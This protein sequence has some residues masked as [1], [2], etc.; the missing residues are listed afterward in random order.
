M[1]WINLNAFSAYVIPVAVIAIVVFGL[2]RRVP[3]FDTFLSGAKE[4]LSSSLSIL[5][6]LV[7]LIVAVTMLNASGALE[8]LTSFLAP[9]TNALGF[10]SEVMPMALLRPI[11]GSGSTAMLTQIFDSFGPD[12]F[13]GRVASVIMGS[14]ETTFYA[15]AVYFA[16]VGIKKTRHAVPAA[17]AADFTGYVMS[18]LS[19]HLFFR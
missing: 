19:I 18:V 17:L 10:P 14:T 12:S 1:S 9:V 7:G 6:S 11:S 13:I 4:G 5:P 15:I 16:A 2:V 3:V 8:L